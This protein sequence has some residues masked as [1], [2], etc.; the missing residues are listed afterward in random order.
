MVDKVTV[1][2]HH[3]YGS[4]VGNSFKAIL[5]GIIL[6]IVSIRL[7]AWNEKNYVETKAAL[8]EWASIVNETTA[9]QINPDFEWKEVYLHWET[10]SNDETLVDET[11]WVKTDNLKLKRTVEMYQWYEESDESCSD[12]LWW[13]E[14]CTTTYNY[15]KKW[16]N[17]AIDS[18]NFYSTNWHENPTT[19]EYNSTE[20]EKSPITLWTYTLSN[21]FISQLDNYS[22]IN[23]NEEDITIPENYINN[24]ENFHI[25]DNYIYIFEKIQMS[26]QFEI[27]KSLSQM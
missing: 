3:S 21:I 15:H 1:S 23:L 12:N 6:V 25:Y 22:T 11:F 10:A 24:N 27:L 13:S 20:K 14:D 2:S 8:K 19:R 4:R 18:S 5:W 9:D 26:Q 17:S 7:L 16:S